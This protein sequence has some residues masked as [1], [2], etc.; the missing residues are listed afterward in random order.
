[1]GVKRLIN[2]KFGLLTVIKRQG[3]NKQRLAMYL[4]K[5]DCG[6]SKLIAG[7]YLRDG[8]SKSCGC[9][10]KAMLMDRENKQRWES[11]FK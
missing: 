10:R 8:R 9:M 4:C 7:R 6:N 1:M 11:P 5:C 3:S 2:S